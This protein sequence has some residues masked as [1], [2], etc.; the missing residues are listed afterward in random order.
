MIQ[1]LQVFLTQ[2][3]GSVT[4]DWVVLTA[5]IFGFIAIVGWSVTDS[6][7]V[8]VLG[9]KISAFIDSVDVFDE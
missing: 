4:V 2:E 5:A 3:D 7:S 8:S 6:V 9:L 1:Q